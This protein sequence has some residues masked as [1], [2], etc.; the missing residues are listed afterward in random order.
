MGVH[1]NVGVYSVLFAYS[2]KYSNY[3]FRISVRGKKIPTKIQKL[4]QMQNYKKTNKM[5]MI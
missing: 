1:S 3:V 4:G 2:K 5:D